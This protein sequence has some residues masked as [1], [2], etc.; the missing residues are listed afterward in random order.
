MKYLLS[1]IFLISFLSGC[2]S[3]PKLTLKGAA[4]APSA[5]SVGV[6]PSSALLKIKTLW[7]SAS[8]DCSSPQKVFDIDNPEAKDL[9]TGPTLGAGPIYPGTYVC[10]IVKFSDQVTFAPSADTG[11]YC[12]AGVST[13]IDVFN[14]GSV[15]SV[16]PDG[17]VTGHGTVYDNKIEDWGCVTF[18]TE[19]LTTTVRGRGSSPDV[20]YKLSAP[21][22]ISSN[23]ED[24]TIIFYWNFTDKV[25]D[26]IAPG[27]TNCS[28]DPGD[29]SLQ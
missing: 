9:V 4:Q 21:V 7:L 14:E 2:G 8:L 18:T 28:L 23:D 13:T 11:L 25:S 15:V 22:Q 19:G 1:A 17:N 3:S 26:E 16:C 20:A 10:A 5:S 6:S 12:K 27:A 29:L 24:K